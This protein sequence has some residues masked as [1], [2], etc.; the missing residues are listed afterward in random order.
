ML[1]SLALLAP[2]PACKQD[3]QTASAPGAA[4]SPAATAAGDPLTPS[5]AARYDRS[6][7]KKGCE[8]LTA[9]GVSQAFGVPAGA[10]KQIKVM[11]CVYTWRDRDQ[12]LEAGVSMLRAHRSEAMAASWFEDA[13]RNR[14]AEENQQALDL[15]MGRVKEKAG[16]GKLGGGVTPGAVDTVG[17]TLAGAVDPGGT[18]YEDI[19]GVGAA[20]RVQLGDGAIW[21]R[22]ANL[23]FTASGYQG[24]RQ[25]RPALPTGKLEEIARAS[26]EAQRAWRAETFEQ[27]KAGSLKVAELVLANLD[28]M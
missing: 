26:Q 24:P 6:I 3:G 4:G 17:K 8:I 15:A 12:V 10:L 5:R 2:L 13:T 22:V 20:A 21:V 28:R 19:D 18:R 14:T 11:G 1:L 27:R 25:P 16:D 9:E 7:S 23:T